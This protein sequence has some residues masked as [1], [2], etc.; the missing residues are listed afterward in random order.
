[1]STELGKLFIRLQGVVPELDFSSEKERD[2][3]L[4]YVNKT[5][6]KRL[7]QMLKTWQANQAQK[8]REPVK[9]AP[10]EPDHI[11]RSRERSEQRRASQ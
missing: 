1:M 10:P 7:S 3:F 5:L 11:R 9:E 2:E 4:A 6:P 8:E